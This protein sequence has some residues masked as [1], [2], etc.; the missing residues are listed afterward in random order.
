M[1][2]RQIAAAAAAALAS[3]LLFLGG[4][5]LGP[6]GWMAWLAPLPVLL[7]AH[8][9][10]RAWLAFAAGFAAYLIGQSGLAFVY[11]DALP[12]A[13]ILIAMALPSVVF[14][15]VMLLAR[16]SARLPVAVAVL[17]PA[18]A[19]T[20]WEYLLSL[21]SPH[22]T[23]GALGYAQ[24]ELLPIVQ[25]A[26]VT[27]VWGLSFLTMLVPSALAIAL[28]RQRR[29]RLALLTAALP[30]LLAL[31][32]GFIRL[33][34]PHD[35][36]LRVGLGADDRQLAHR[37]LDASSAI[38]AA[39]AHADLVASI[40]A[41]AAEERL[42]VI[43]LPEKAI[44]LRPAWT[45]DA[46]SRIAA[47]AAAA[48]TTVVVGLD[49]E[50]AAGVRRNVAAVFDP[51]GNLRARYVKRHLVPGLE[52][53]FTAGDSPLVLDGRGV[54]I[55]KDLDFTA[56]GREQGRRG[57]TALLVP[58]WDFGGDAR[59]HAR[60]AIVRAVESGFALVRAAQEGLLTVSDR[61]G[62]IVA[63]EASRA[64]RPVL[65]TAEVGLAP[66]GT[67]YAAAGDVFAWLVLLAAAL[68]GLLLAARRRQRRAA[69]G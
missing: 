10:P 24:A 42:D 27:G 34:Q 65:L 26:S 9:A 4:T 16:A 46:Q 19:W 68:T 25:L 1:S 30:L 38:A 18:L 31:G 23:A 63:E 64:D 44:T 14:A 39:R 52:E 8:R 32:F 43:L 2:A 36:R 20:S 33:A 61:N 35:G 58:A 56:L 62:R 54:A 47:A 13:L 5:G 66:G 12:L 51:Q 60:M 21:V 55:C 17:A 57:A 45:G 6:W 29:A 22:G 15:A 49:E 37:A 40:V 11:G 41:R 48:G 59:L 53:A 50:D 3:G 67:I 28:A 7:L 69:P